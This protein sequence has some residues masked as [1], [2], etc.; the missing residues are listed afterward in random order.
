MKKSF[1]KVSWVAFFVVL[2]LGPSG[3]SF[4]LKHFKYE[5]GWKNMI[6]SHVLEWVFHF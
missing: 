2:G 6:L 4:S 3:I 1:T 5:I